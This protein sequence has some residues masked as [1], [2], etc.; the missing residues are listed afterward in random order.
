MADPVSAAANIATVLVVTVQTCARLVEFYQKLTDAPA[1]VRHKA[2][3]LKALQSTFSELQTLVRDPRFSDFQAHLPAGFD[4]R[5]AD[6]GADLRQMESRV[7][8]VCTRLDGGRMVQT[9]A[10]VKHSFAGEQWSVG[11]SRRLQMYHSA[12]SIDLAT[13]QM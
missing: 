4:A 1:E 11:C 7:R 12:F 8:R 6:C 3:W 13:I 2:L 9:W 10:R 5:L